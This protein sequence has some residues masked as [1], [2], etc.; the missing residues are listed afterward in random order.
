MEKLT[1]DVL[2]GRLSL[3]LGFIV[4]PFVCFIY[5]IMR[6]FNKDKSMPSREISK[7]KLLYIK[8]FLYCVINIFLIFYLSQNKLVA[9]FMFFSLILFFMILIRLIHLIL[10]SKKKNRNKSRS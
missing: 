4:F 5:I 9:N 1:V 6:L 7:S 3:Y 8:L 2:V 10:L